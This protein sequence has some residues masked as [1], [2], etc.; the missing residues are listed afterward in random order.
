MEACVLATAVD[1][2][3]FGPPKA[4]GSILL[5]LRRKYIAQ[6]KRTTRGQAYR[7]LRAGRLALERHEARARRAVAR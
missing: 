5:L 7:V 3:V 4:A 6:E 1:G 2:L